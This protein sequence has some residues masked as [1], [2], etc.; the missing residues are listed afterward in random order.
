MDLSEINFILRGSRRRKILNSLKNSKGKNTSF[1]SK[2]LKLSITNTSKTLK[3]L[4]EKSYI[5]C[6]NKNDYHYKIYELTKKGELTIIE[7][8][9]LL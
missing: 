5:Q 9:K 8:D 2:E 7:I 1:I 6:K 3:E 4:E